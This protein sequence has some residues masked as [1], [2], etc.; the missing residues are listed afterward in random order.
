MNAA[1]IAFTYVTREP[2]G[3]N[4]WAQLIARVSFQKSSGEYWLLHGECFALGTC[5]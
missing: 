3:N 1:V 2:V 5:F 4:S